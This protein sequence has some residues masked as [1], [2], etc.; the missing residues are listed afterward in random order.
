[1]ETLQ[2]I[3]FVAINQPVMIVPFE[4]V[5]RADLLSDVVSEHNQCQSNAAMNIRLVSI[6]DTPVEYVEGYTLNGHIEH[7]FNRALDGRGEYVYFDATLDPTAEYYYAVR[8]FSSKQILDVF[9][10][11]KQ[12]FFT[13][14]P[15]SIVGYARYPFSYDDNGNLVKESRETFGLRNSKQKEIVRILERLNNGNKENDAGQDIIL[16]HPTAHPR[17]PLADFR[18]PGDATDPRN[19]IGQ[20]KGVFE[21]SMCGGVVHDIEPC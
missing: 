7:A 9:D 6:W 1:M 18:G 14:A 10:H 4:K 15:T 16:K 5:V 2:H 11:Y 12:S 3:E 8:A 21:V 13:F 19:Q 17:R 20:N